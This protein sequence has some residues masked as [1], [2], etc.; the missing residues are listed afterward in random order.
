MDLLSI[1]Y[2]SVYCK[3]RQEIVQIMEKFSKQLDKMKQQQISELINENLLTL[4]QSMELLNGTWNFCARARLACV[5]QMK[6]WD[7]T[8]LPPSV[9]A[10]FLRL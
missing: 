4:I 3:S 8:G 10:S 5:P 6:A 9:F 1:N 7:C 2:N